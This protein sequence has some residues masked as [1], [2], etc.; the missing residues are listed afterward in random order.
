[1]N[2][3]IDRF[4]E[5]IAENPRYGYLIAGGLGGCGMPL[6]RHGVNKLRL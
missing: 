5:R 1:M 4:S 3:Q 2:E 6:L